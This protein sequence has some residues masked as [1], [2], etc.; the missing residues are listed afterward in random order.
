MTDC[1]WSWLVRQGNRKSPLGDLARDAKSE[2]GARCCKPHFTSPEAAESH[3]RL[4][5]HACGGALRAMANAWR[6]YS[7]VANRE[8]ATHL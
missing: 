7:R 1:F 8:R 5:H 6:A 3:L 4:H 2:R